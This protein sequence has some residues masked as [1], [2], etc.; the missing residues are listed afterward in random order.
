LSAGDTRSKSHKG[1]SRGRS[2]SSDIHLMKERALA[3]EET[4]LL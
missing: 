2:F 1:F 3:P 4:L